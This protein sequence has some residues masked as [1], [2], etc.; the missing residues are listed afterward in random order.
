MELM[1]NGQGNLH[2]VQVWINVDECVRVI[3]ELS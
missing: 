1:D 3:E 2:N